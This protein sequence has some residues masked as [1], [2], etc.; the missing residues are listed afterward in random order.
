MSSR[1]TDDRGTALIGYA[2]IVMLIG[3]VSIGALKTVGQSTSD[4]FETISASIPGSSVEANVVLTPKEKW[5]QAKADY[6]AAIAAAKATKSNDV[7]KAAA[8]YK[9]TIQVNKSLLSKAE[10]KTANKQAKTTYKAAKKTANNTY[11]ASVT[12]A[13]SAKAAAKAEYNATK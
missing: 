13:K 5:N 10:K 11:K 1:N 6:T 9:A 4:S 8:D 12:A 7:A 3:V 2:L